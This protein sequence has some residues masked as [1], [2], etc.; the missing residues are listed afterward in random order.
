MFEKKDC[1]RKCKKTDKINNMLEEANLR[2]WS[3]VL[4]SKKEI[5]KR[6]L[7]AGIARGLGMTIGLA[8]ITTVI[9][10]ILQRIVKMNIPLIGD[11][12][13]D[14]IEIVEKRR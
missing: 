9:I 2:E 3:Y 6:N 7:I 8:I 13:I 10:Y 12:I 1:K 14:L 4:G 5:F 11:Y